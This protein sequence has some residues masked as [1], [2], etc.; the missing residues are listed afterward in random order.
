MNQINIKN[1]GY[2][3]KGEYNSSLS[4]EKNDVVIKEDGSVYVNTSST[5]TPVWELSTAGYNQG[6]DLSA[7]AGE[8]ISKEFT[9][10]TQKLVGV[11]G[12]QIRV[13]SDN[14]L[15][16]RFSDERRSSGIVS[17][18]TTQT[19][20]GSISGGGWTHML[21]VMTD[22][23]V[24]AWG[25]QDYGQQGD[26]IATKDVTTLT[27][28]P[29]TMP[30]PRGTPPIVKAVI[31][32]FHSFLI[33]ANGGLWV[34]GRNFSGILGV[35]TSGEDEFISIPQKINGKGDLPEDAVVVD[36]VLRSGPT[37]QTYSNYNYALIRTQDGLV[38]HTGAR[39]TGVAGDGLGQAIG[40]L[41]L[42]TTP[43]L[44]LISKEINV[45]KMFAPCTSEV[46]N[47]SALIDDQGR[48]WL[49]GGYLD[50][51]TVSDPDL[52]QSGSVVMTSGRNSDMVPGGAIHR[53]WKPSETKAVKS[54]T[55]S[56]S[57][58]F[59]RYMIIHENGHL[60]TYGD[61]SATSGANVSAGYTDDRKWI[62]TLDNRLISSIP[63]GNVPVKEAYVAMGTGTSSTCKCSQIILSTNGS[64]YYVGDYS[65]DIDRIFRSDF[66][67]RG[68][69]R[70][71]RWTHAAYLGQDNKEI[72][73][74]SA[75]DSD[76]RSL[77]VLKNDGAVY[78]FGNT[79]SGWIGNGF[80]ESSITDISKN[81][82]LIREEIIGITFAGTN[83]NIGTQAYYH[84]RS[85]V[86]YACGYINDQ[87]T[88]YNGSL[89]TK[90][91]PSPLLVPCPV[92]TV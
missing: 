40:E 58:L 35:G 25:R 74:W 64:I 28:T 73:F 19:G 22:G 63:S 79:Q 42:N 36:V 6:L 72:W 86:I 77:A 67:P 8:L 43:K 78:G 91:G 20:K 5:N 52:G 89:G 1:L 49:A 23:S 82:T 75:E 83:N 76:H 27:F 55:G 29:K 38:Y 92:F 44:V 61:V 18:A 4:Y 87:S 71:D 47:V 70:A 81:K 37:S 56:S 60:V 45:V 32:V 66:E 34:C 51:G 54:F 31:D 59:R 57:A 48:L 12:Q 9:P 80:T 2:R 53:L 17:L 68:G 13:K 15:E 11:T 3:W 39:H 7:N 88:N 14:S 69:V 33:D 26:G 90:H 50:T 24:Q 84:G 21:A 62:P 46:A 30:L 10:G 16:Y 65:S 41:L 85:G